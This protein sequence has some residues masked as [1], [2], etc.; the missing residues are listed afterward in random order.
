VKGWASPAAAD[1]T[2]RVHALDLMGIDRQILFPIAFVAAILVSPM[3]GAAEACRIHNDYIL[4][5]ARAG[6]GRL[7]PVAMVPTQTV[8]GALAE[9]KRTIDA[10]AYA[11][12]VSSGRPPGG[13]S[14]ADP[15]WD[16][17]WALVAEV[18]VPVLLHIGGESGFVDRAWGRI[19]SIDERPG[20]RGG[21]ALGPYN[22]VTMHM[23]P[24]AFLSSMVLGGVFERH[25]RLR[26]GVI[27][28]GAQWVGPMAD[29][30]D[31]RTKVKLP[32]CPPLADTLPM[33]PSEYLARNVRVTPFH[34]E[35]IGTYI[36]RYGLEDVYVFSTDFPHPEGGRHP[37]TDM[38]ESVERLGDTVIEKLFVT[39]GELLL[40]K[41]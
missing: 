17:F 38:Y 25:P 4:D 30:M 1:A 12:N 2:L 41:P 32:G 9:A 7:R 19:A 5:W 29:L 16:P 10:G 37:I 36:E 33:K 18:D 11:I 24:Q 31:Q 13:L 3:E 39:N 15:A 22:L 20:T 8:E 35:P 27:E 23:A 28:L 40:P 26:F 6:K 21:E 34:F 14:P